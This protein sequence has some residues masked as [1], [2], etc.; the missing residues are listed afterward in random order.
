MSRSGCDQDRS[1]GGVGGKSTNVVSS[2]AVNAR[3]P[4][5]IHRPLVDHESINR[6][7]ERR[8]LCSLFWLKLRVASNR[9]TYTAVKLRAVGAAIDGV[10]KLPGKK[11]LSSASLTVTISGRVLRFCRQQA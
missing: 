11:A 8:L 4:R 6:L 3:K 2:A 5:L 9:A 7:T 10:S 1:L